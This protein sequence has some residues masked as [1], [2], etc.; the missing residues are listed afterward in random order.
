MKNI[1]DLSGKTILITGASSGIGAETAVLCSQ[2]GAKIILVARREEKLREI[3]RQL[4]SSGHT[5]YPF[6]LGNVDEIEGFIK[7]IIDENGP[8]DGFVHSAGIPGTRPLKLFKPKAMREIMDI[9]FGSFVEIVR[10]ITKK[11][12]FRSG[13]SIIGVS[14]AASIKGGTGNTGYSA[15]KAAMNAAVRCIA[16]ELSREGIRANTISPGVIDTDIYQKT[17]DNGGDSMDNQ[18]KL[19]RQY[20]GLGKP[21]DVA[22]MIAFLLSDASRMITGTNVVIDGGM[23]TS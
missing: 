5:Y 20:L 14:S 4:E 8:L 15:S 11:K 17:L 13:M 7:R 10:C 18:L 1:I 22:N 16:K 21:V 2:V 6:D 23:L 9:N 19:Y 12:A 3:T